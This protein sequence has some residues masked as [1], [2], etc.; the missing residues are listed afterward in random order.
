MHIH[1][2]GLNHHTAKLALRERLA[3]TEESAK[4]CL[5]RLGCGVES[6]LK[7]AEQASELVILSTC[8]RIELYAVASQPSPQF[9]ESILVE[10]RGVP[11]KELRD[12][13]YHYLDEQAV[14]HL[15]RVAAGLDSLV[16]GEPQILGQVMSALEMARSQGSTGPILSRL[17]Q[18]A[19]YTGKRARTETAISHNPASISS[20]AVRLAEQ[21]VHNIKEVQVGVIGAGEMAELA[22]EA[23]RKRGA[24]HVQVINRTLERARQLAERWGGQACTFENLPKILSELDILITSTGAPHTLVHPDTLVPIMA[25]RPDRHLVIIDIAVPRDVDVQVGE[26]PGI[27]LYD[28]DTLHKHLESSLAM[29]ALEVPRVEEILTEEKAYFLQYLQTLDVVP[30]IS[31]LRHYAEQI[32]QAELEKTLRRLPGLT[33]E[34][35]KRLDVMTQ[36]LVKKLLHNPITRLRAGVRDA[37]GIEVALAARNLFGLTNQHGDRPDSYPQ[38]GWNA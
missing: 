7:P 9:L 12:S 14:N 3:F 36:A 4:A 33:E 18:S 5:A 32:R 2:L 8:N 23:L 20:V 17:F 37:N 25:A 19:L 26:I 1:C 6:S 21:T 28:M 38:D 24:V 15:F 34:E 35:Q 10:V 22:V 16:L 29:R 30:L 13:M 11:L 27:C 31:E